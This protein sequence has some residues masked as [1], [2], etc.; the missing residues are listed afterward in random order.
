M[1]A[2]GPELRPPPWKT[3]LD[4]EGQDAGHYRDFVNEPLYQQID[5]APGRVLELGCAAGM[6]GQVL[7]ERHPGTHVTGIEAGQAAA[8]V[9]LTRLDRVICQRIEDVDFAALGIGAGSFDLVVAGDVLEHLN[10]PW[11]ALLRVHPLI[12]PGGRLV[13]S[14]PNVRNLQVIGSLVAAGRFEYA[15]R[16]LLDIT[17]LRFFALDDLRLAFESTGYALESFSFTL[18]PGLQALYHEHQGKENVTIRV[19]K[20]TLADVTPR[21]LIEFCAET[22]SVRA[23]PRR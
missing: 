2:T 14:I 7:K 10:N 3:C 8:A 15:E 17:H 23:R 16:G 9:A 12:A 4:I 21:E 11:D 6:F 20:M 19:G 5:G 18:S 13:A 1:I 22:Y